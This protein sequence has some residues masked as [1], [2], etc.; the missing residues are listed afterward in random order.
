MPCGMD[1][2][3]HLETIAEHVRPMFGKGHVADYI[4]ALAAVPPDKF[5]MA[6]RTIEGDC[7]SIGDAD[8]RFSIQSISKIFAMSLAISQI[9]DEL[10]RRVGREPSGNAFNSLVQLEVENGKPRN[11]MINAGAL[12]V[13]DVLLTRFG[14][15]RKTLLDYMR[16]LAGSHDVVFDDA[17]AQS[18]LETGYG[19][20]ALANYLKR[21]GNLENEPAE[22]V[23]LYCY[24][25][26]LSMSCSELAR[27]SNH[28]ANRGVTP[29]PRETVL[30]T[31]QVKRVNAVMMTCGL[32]DAVGEFAY[33]VGLPGKSGVGGGIIAVLPDAY[34]VAVWSPELD[35]F[36]NSM[37]G[38]AALEH[39]TTLT[40][41]SVF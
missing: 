27:A 39:L 23:D 26:A 5:G 37:V 7:F 1:Y 35:P 12:V 4:P 3:H 29:R 19:N 11:P 9:G 32:Y 33:R 40:G 17:V 36:G 14:D 6:L 21:W 22:V 20:L 18:E 28:L 10:W 41:R 24:Q 16:L 8:E 34:S 2:Q 13:S 31:Q 38:G 30:T 25:C 15:A